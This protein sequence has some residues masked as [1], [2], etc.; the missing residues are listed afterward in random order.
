LASFGARF[1]HATLVAASGLLTVF[2]AEMDFDAGDMFRQVAERG[3]H[4]GFGPRGQS[5]AT[6]DVVVA[7]D[8][9]FHGCRLYRAEISRVGL[10]KLAGHRLVTAILSFFAFRLRWPLATGLPLM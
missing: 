8:L 4:G 10:L 7:V 9:D 5:L 2:I 1:H 3:G 6:G